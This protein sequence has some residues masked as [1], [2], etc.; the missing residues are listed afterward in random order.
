MEYFVVFFGMFASSFMFLF[1]F[2][3]NGSRTGGCYSPVRYRNR[4]MISLAVA[5]FCTILLQILR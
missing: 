4:F 5:S 2:G 1:T 3:I